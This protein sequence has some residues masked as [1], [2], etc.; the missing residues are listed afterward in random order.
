MFEITISLLGQDK[1]ETDQR[2]G[3]ERLKHSIVKTV[4]VPGLLESSFERI[5][6]VVC[7]L[8][9]FEGHV[10]TLLT[11]LR[12][13]QGHFKEHAECLGFLFG[14]IFHELLVGGEEWETLVIEG[15]GVEGL[16]GHLGEE[17]GHFGKHLIGRQVGDYGQFHD[18]AGVVVVMEGVESL[19]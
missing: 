2:L 12:L 3:S 1:R 10:Q 8:H 13:V 14:H 4:D 15:E 9:E 16:V 7:Y 18:V 17:G 11:I 5:R 19:E 6:P